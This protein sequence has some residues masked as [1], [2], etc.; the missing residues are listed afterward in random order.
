MLWKRPPRPFLT[1]VV[2][3]V[4]H[5]VFLATGHQLLWDAAFGGVTPTLGGNLSRIDPAT[6]EGIIRTTAAVS[7]LVT[8]TLVGVVTEAVAHLLNRVVPAGQNKSN[9]RPE[10]HHPGGRAPDAGRSTRR[11]Q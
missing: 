11:G 5:G 9:G 8:G 3:G 6:E 4:L 7:S 2:I 1:V 10:R